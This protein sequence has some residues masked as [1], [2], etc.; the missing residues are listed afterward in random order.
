MSSIIPRQAYRAAYRAQQAT[1]LY[2]CLAAHQLLRAVTG[3]R[4]QPTVAAVREVRKRYAELLERDLDNVERGYYP[5]RLLFQ[6]PVTDYAK[7]F[8]R[9]VRDFPRAVQRARRKDFKD[10]PP[11]VDL[12]P[13]PH[14]FRRNF[15]WQTDGYLSRRSAELY[16]VGVELLF[17]GMADVMRRQVIPP[18]ARFM[19]DEEVRLKRPLRVLDVA[20]G[21]GRTLRQL[22]SAYP[23]HRYYGLDLSP[24]YVQ[25]ARQQLGDLVHAS[26][27]T[28]N[29]EHM[30]FRDDYFDVV[31]SVY[32]FHELPSNARR[33][34]FR[35]MHRVLRPGGLVVIEDSAQRSDAGEV[36]FFLERFSEEFHEPFYRDY[37]AEDLAD[38]LPRAGFVVDAVDSC[39][40]AKVVTATKPTSA[41]S[42]A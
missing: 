15:H 11:D 28:D 37:L 20:C 14:Y 31:T 23:E 36:A 1:F 21:T 2:Q 33:N 26:F 35:E 22:A 7:L 42:A 39:F 29:A 40:V 27:V 4:I 30:P 13:Y 6:V 32:L 12:G 25:V 24:Y 34:V 9:L 17:L 16:D 19:R 5:Q 41:Q 3:F 18:V 38:A 8:P 10:L